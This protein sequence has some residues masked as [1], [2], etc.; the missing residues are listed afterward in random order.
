[1][2]LGSALRRTS[3]GLPGS[4]NE[5]GRLMLPYLAFLRAGFALPPLS[6][7]AR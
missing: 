6:P 7:G 1:M 2:H 4:P 5:A 3:N